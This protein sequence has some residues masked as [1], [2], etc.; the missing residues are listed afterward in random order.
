V[1]R[2]NSIYYKILVQHQPVGTEEKPQKNVITVVFI[3]GQYSN[4]KFRR[5]N[6]PRQLP[7]LL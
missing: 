1:K 2:S 5:L 6:N 4:K 7:V 3:V